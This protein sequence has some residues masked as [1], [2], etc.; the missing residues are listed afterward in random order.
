MWSCEKG[1]SQVAQTLLARGA[2]TG[3]MDQAGTTAMDRA[4][5]LGHEDLVTLLKRYSKK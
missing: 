3:A 1:L 4:V 2:D 5:K